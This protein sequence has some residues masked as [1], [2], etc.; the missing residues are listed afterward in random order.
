MLSCKKLRQKK[1]WEI[2]R[3]SK[4]HSKQGQAIVNWKEKLSVESTQGNSLLHCEINSKVSLIFDALA[5]CHF[6]RGHY[7]SVPE[8]V[9]RDIQV[10]LISKEYA[11]CTLRIYIIC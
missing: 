3:Y 5:S 1:A 4:K 8:S 10:R 7:E 2:N 11:Y 6:G 9:S